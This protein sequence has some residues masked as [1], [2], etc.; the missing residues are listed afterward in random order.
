MVTACRLI[1]SADGDFI[2]VMP[3]ARMIR[4]ITADAAIFTS[5]PN[6]QVK[7]ASAV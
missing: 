7:N 4:L 6:D 2:A 3:A 5:V 1:R